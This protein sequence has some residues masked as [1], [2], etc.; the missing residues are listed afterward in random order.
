MLDVAVT[1]AALGNSGLVTAGWAAGAAGRL[2]NAPAAGAGAMWGIP[3]L[4]TMWGGIPKD[5]HTSFIE[6]KHA[7]KGEGDHL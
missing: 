3:G 7:G 1:C 2:G 4:G 6:I 5:R